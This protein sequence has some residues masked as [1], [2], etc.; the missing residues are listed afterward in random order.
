[1]YV[2]SDHV[3]ARPIIAQWPGLN[4]NFLED[5][6]LKI[7]LDYRDVLSEI[8]SKRTPNT[9]LLTVFP[10]HAFREAGILR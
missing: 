4:A 2:M 10:D 9:D 8:L 7:T 3:V 6:D 1:M 5:G